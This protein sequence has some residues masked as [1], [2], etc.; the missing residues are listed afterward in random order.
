MTAVIRGEA[1]IS[2]L[3]E[4]VLRKRTESAG[5]K[6]LGRIVD[7]LGVR[8]RPTKQQAMRE[9]AIERQLSGVI[10]RVPAIGSHKNWAEIRI[11]TDELAVRVK[12]AG[13]GVEVLI[14]EEPLAAGSN[15]RSSENEITREFAL[16]VQVPLMRQRIAQIAGNR[17]DGT[18][19]TSRRREAGQ[20]TGSIGD[21]A[22][23]PGID[24]ILHCVRRTGSGVIENI[25]EE[26]VV[27]D[28]VASTDDGFVVSKKATP[29]VRCI[30]QAHPWREII[31]VPLLLAREDAR[32]IGSATQAD[33]EPG[34]HS[35]KLQRVF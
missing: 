5:D 13:A 23:A 21:T 2:P 1:A 25:G 26:L 7:E 28:S 33:P 12:L 24:C 18:R 11:H 30:G 31:F 29:E 34:V 9:L 19:R 8:V 10:D 35:G 20:N 14:D 32:K 3:V 15:I 17:A 6:H 27:K 16:N 22:T 4:N